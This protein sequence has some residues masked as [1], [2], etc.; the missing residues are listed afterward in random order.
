MFKKTCGYFPTNDKKGNNSPISEIARK[1]KS[2]KRYNKGYIL[3]LFV[4]M[5]L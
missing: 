2:D 3:F 1:E 4:L 5:Q